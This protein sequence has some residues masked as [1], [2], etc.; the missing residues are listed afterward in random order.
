M[1]SLKKTTKKSAKKSTGKKSPIGEEYYVFVFDTFSEAKDLH[2]VRAVK[3]VGKLTQDQ[4]DYLCSEFERHNKMGR[5]RFI[6]KH[7]IPIDGGFVSKMLHGK[8]TELLGQ[9]NVHDMDQLMINMAIDLANAIRKRDGCEQ[10]NIARENS[11]V[12]SP[13]N[14]VE[15]ESV[16]DDIVDLIANMKGNWVSQEKF[17]DEDINVNRH[18]VTKSG[19]RHS[20]EEGNV[21]W[22]LKDSK[23]GKDKD[24]HFLERRGKNQY[25][26]RYRYF[27]PDEFNKTIAPNPSNEQ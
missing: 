12:T 4:Y 24:G 5:V 27:L 25:A 13:A 19:L 8:I 20:R 23:I 2:N 7:S 15:T 21:V 11:T 16:Q 17:L 9:K 26:Y 22:S 1:K 18:T 10:W 6:S 3:T 14:P